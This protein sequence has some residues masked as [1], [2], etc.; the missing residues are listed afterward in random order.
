MSD[1]IPLIYNLFPRYYRTIE[2]WC[3]A[4][5]HIAAMAFTAV[6]VNPFH[7][8]G[9]SGSL[10]SVKDYFR[11]NPLFLEPGADGADFAP[12]SQFI[13][14]CNAAGL[15]PAMDLVINH[16]AIDSPLVPSTARGTNATCRAGLRHLLPLIPATR[17]R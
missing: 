13:A 3:G 9:F 17:P 14:R 16:T 7:E 11:L 2:E 15:Q 5:P 6:F 10:Y 4:V 12:L 8:T 1:R